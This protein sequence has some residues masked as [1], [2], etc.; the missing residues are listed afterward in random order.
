MGVREID[1]GGI[2]LFLK[3]L[4]IVCPVQNFNIWDAENSRDG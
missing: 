4:A 1:E 2:N 3:Y